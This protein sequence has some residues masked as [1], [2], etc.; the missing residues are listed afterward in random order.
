M[1]EQTGLNINININ[2]NI[3]QYQTSNVYLDCYEGRF[4]HRTLIFH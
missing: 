2:V 3:V 4:F 1:I